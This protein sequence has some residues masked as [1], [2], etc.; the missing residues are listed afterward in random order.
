MNL[1]DWEFM[2][3]PH[4]GGSWKSHRLGVHE[5]I[6]VWKF[7]KIS[8]IGVHGNLTDW[9]FMKITQIGVH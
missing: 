8:Q 3:I 4:I 1:T 6:A 5:D 7:I 9:E 2:K